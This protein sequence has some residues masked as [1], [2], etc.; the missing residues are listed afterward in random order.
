MRHD[1]GP[2]VVVIPLY[3]TQLPEEERIALANNVRALSNHPLSIVCPASLDLEPLQEALAPAQD[4]ALEIFPDHCFDGVSGYNRMM[5]SESFYER[6]GGYRHLLVCQTDAFVF[7]DE[8]GQWCARD[9]DYIG[10]PWIS[11]E[12]TAWNRALFDFNNLF[13]KKKKHDDYLFKVGNGGF[14]LRNVA[15]MQRIVRDQRANIEHALANPSDDDHHIEDRYFSLVAPKIFPQMR[16]P[17][18]REAV[19]FCIDRRPQLAMQMHAGRLPFACHGFNKRKVAA[20]WKP[21]IER[22]LAQS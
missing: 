19:G 4:R 9:H 8:L 18:Y 10:A 21:L 13:R 17:D 5:L 3:T 12:R 20:F 7:R 6:F 16:I 1:K 11:S 22:A 14:S 2:V 15:M